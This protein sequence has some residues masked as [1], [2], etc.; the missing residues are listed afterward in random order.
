MIQKPINLAFDEA[1]QKLINAIN[2]SYSELQVPYFLIE[3]ILKELHEEIVNATQQEKQS[4]KNQYEKMLKIEKEKQ[5]NQLGLE[6][7]TK[8]EV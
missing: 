2:E 1:K 3:I 8:S 6:A 7:D 4:A 5:A